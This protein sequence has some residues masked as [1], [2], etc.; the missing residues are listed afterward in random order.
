MADNKP[1]D[2]KKNET[3]AAAPG[4]IKAMLPLILAVVLM[5]VLAYVMT[6]FVLVPKL[7][8][9]L[10]AGAKTVDGG[11]HAEES[12]GEGDGHGDGHGEAT[13]GAV[14]PTFKLQKLVVNVR[15]SLATRYLMSSFTLVG[16]GKEFNSLIT[17]NEDQLRDVAMGVLSSKSISDL[18]RPGARNEIRNEL[19]STFNTALGKPL[20]QDLYIT[21][22]AIQ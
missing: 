11:E 18:E 22:F 6:Q 20:V 3:P 14:D 13:P 4:G 15:G 12:T 5:P 9:A 8:N 1:T 7:Q 19:V 2:D 21:E 16:K 10:V 17:A